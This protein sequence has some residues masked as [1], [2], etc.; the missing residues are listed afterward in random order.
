[1]MTI[2]SFD[3]I[4]VFTSTQKGSR[5]TITISMSD[6]NIAIELTK[7]NAEWLRYALKKAIELRKS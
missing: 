6:G 1:M 3:E 4:N 5:I 7:H 2:D